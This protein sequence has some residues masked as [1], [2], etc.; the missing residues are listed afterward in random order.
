MKALNDGIAEFNSQTRNP[1]NLVIFSYAAQHVLRVSR[2]IRQ[3]FGNALL[4]GFGGGGRQSLTKLATF[5]AGFQLFQV[6]ITK[7]YGTNEWQEDLKARL[8][9]LSPRSKINTVSMSPATESSL[10]H[11]LHVDDNCLVLAIIAAGLLEGIHTDS[12]DA[13]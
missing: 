11:V 13:L 7:L 12:I 4:V 8:L 3:P 2:T 10:E 1:M 9:L 5:M 6:T